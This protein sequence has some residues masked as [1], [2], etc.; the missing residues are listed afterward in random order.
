MNA[1]MSRSVARLIL[2][3]KPGHTRADADSA[4]KRLASTVHPDVCRGPEA[5][6][7]TQIALDARRAV[8]ASKPPYVTG[9]QRWA[10]GTWSM[11]IRSAIRPVVGEVITYV[12]DADLGFTCQFTLIEV[13]ENRIGWFTC[14]A[15]LNPR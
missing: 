13:I 9:V 2:G 3:L 11:K 14:R 8:L 15:T 10:D 7:L 6:R 5:K 1:A 4:L 12:Q